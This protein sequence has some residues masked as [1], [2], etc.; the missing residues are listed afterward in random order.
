MVACRQTKQKIAKNFLRIVSTINLSILEPSHL[1]SHYW[2][3]LLQPN[4]LNEDLSRSCQ[5][6]LR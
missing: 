3:F 4:S 2:I 5:L 6:Y 1:I